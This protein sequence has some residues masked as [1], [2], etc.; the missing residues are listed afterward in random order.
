MVYCIDYLRENL[1]W[2]RQKL[3]PFEEGEAHGGLRTSSSRVL[4]AGSCSSRG[5]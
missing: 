1:D 5:D 3:K 4:L 2:L